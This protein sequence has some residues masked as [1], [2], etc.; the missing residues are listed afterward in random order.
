MNGSEQFLH[1]DETPRVDFNRDDSRLFNGENDEESVTCSDV[2]IA[3]D[4]LVIG[5][6]LEKIRAMSIKEQNE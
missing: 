6:R 4:A 1:E 5:I 3:R 2:I